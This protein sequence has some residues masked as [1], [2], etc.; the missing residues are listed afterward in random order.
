MVDGSLGRLQSS[1]A[2]TNIYLSYDGSDKIFAFTRPEKK[3]RILCTLLI[4]LLVRRKTNGNTETLITVN[5]FSR[6]VRNWSAA[7]SKVHRI[8]FY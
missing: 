2:A 1:M 7:S 6:G 3:K 5:G 8:E 4:F